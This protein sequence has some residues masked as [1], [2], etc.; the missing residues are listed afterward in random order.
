MLFGSLRRKNK[1]NIT[2]SAFQN[3]L[4]KVGSDGSLSSR[5]VDSWCSKSQSELDDIRS[6][7]DSNG[8]NNRRVTFDE[9]KNKKYAH[10]SEHEYD[11]KVAWYGDEDYARFKREM[12][13]AVESSLREQEQETNEAQ[14]TFY[15]YLQGLYSS[16]QQA[17]KVTLN[18]D[19]VLTERQ[20][21]YLSSLYLQGDRVDMIGL[22]T[23]MLKSVQKDTKS[24]RK[25]VNASL[26]HV[27]DDFKKGWFREED[28]PEE[29]RFACIKQ[30]MPSVLFAQLLAKARSFG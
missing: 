14:K 5:T 17:K 28:F 2:G 30:T 15:L 8:S 21:Q 22:E 16:A 27:K 26:V 20:E 9:S 24:I 3:A 11:G 25:R 12:K 13:E 29:C 1:I 7:A 6:V 18:A 4:H 10:Y 23:H 19:K